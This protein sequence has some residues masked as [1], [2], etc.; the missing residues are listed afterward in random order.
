MIHILKTLLSEKKT[1]LARGTIYLTIATFFSAV[2][3]Y[4]LYFV[5]GRVLGPEQFGIYGVVVGL[6]T[7]L[8]NVI[9]NSLQQ[10][11]SKF[12]SENEKSAHRIKT[13]FLKV[14]LA[15]SIIV[16]LIYIS[17]SKQ[18]ALL[19]NDV[20][21]ANYIRL[22]ALI[23]IPYFLYGVLQGYLNGLRFFKKQ[24]L[25]R[26]IYIVVKVAF[27]IA[28][29]MLGFGVF[30][31]ILGFLLAAVASFLINYFIVGFSSNGKYEP[32]LK[33]MADF[34][35]PIIVS[36]LIINTMANISLLFVKALSPAAISNLKAGYFTAASSIAQIPFIM[37]ASF[38][39][40]IFPAISRNI[41]KKDTG[42]VRKYIN[43]GLR[44]NL[45]ATVLVSVLISSTSY[46]ILHLLY[47][48]KYEAAA[49]PLSIL[50]F[51]FAF[52]TVFMLLATIIMGLGKP[53]TATILSL[54]TLVELVILSI[55]LIPTYSLNGAAVS[56]LIAT[57]T[58]V[59][60]SSIY[61]L[62]KT[63]SL[64]SFASI[65]RIIVSGAIVFLIGN[66][67]HAKGLMLIPYYATLT[68]VYLL[69]LL[70]TREFKKEDFVLLKKTI[71]ERF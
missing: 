26:T 2:L 4:L 41:S 55:F 25:I 23:I 69:M 50:V 22:T 35:V 15:V 56:M 44:Y 11:T 9:P 31:A 8:T 34:A 37:L 61:I 3:G 33:N 60:V 12:I 40:V 18:I 36:T 17:L 20:S 5:L 21:L 6:L 49:A 52:L 43:I 13:K 29:V 54:I 46:G 58:G 65:I 70:L 57:L 66:L 19:L 7:L 62:K 67:I 32:K 10:A 59:I 53:R 38:S 1:S 63:G 68:L 39:I 64:T 48:S 45:I 14:A 27:I 30:G 71:K 51:G 47:T 28:L 42:K 24:A 16:S